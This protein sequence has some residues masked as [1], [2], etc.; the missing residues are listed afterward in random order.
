M[1]NFESSS[2]L[3]MRSRS[4]CDN[5]CVRSRRYHLSRCVIARQTRVRVFV[6]CSITPQSFLGVRGGTAE[7]RRSGRRCTSDHPARSDKFCAHPH[8]DPPHPQMAQ[9]SWDRTVPPYHVRMGK[10]VLEG[11]RLRRARSI[12]S[13]RPVRCDQQRYRAPPQGRLLQARSK[14]ASSETPCGGSGIRTHGTP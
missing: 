12:W 9:S 11:E 6:A 4:L 7:T 5:L 10:G 13:Q 8:C 14:P 3:M 2:I 1:R